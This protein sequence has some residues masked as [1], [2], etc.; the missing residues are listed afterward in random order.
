M[1]VLGIE[2]AVE[3]LGVSAAAVDVLFVLDCELKDEGLVLVGEGLE[4]G[5]GGV[6]LSV[7]AGLNTLALFGIAVELSGCQNEL[8][9]IAALV[10]RRDPSFFPRICWKNQNLMSFNLLKQLFSHF[11]H[12]LR[13]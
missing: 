6:E 9:G 8:A 11:N 10:C 12:L 4:L 5:G 3:E 1:H 7:L 2:R 13:G